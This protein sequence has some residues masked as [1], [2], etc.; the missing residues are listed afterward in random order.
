MHTFSPRAI[1]V[2]ALILALAP[3][4]FAAPAQRLVADAAPVRAAPLAAPDYVIGPDDVLTIVFWRDK[5]MSGDVVVR[6]D[7]RISLPLLNDIQAAGLTPEELRESLVAAAG[8]L[9]EEPSA[10]VVVKQI[11]SRR[12][13]I[14]GEVGKPGPYALTGPMTVVQLIALAGGLNEYADTEH[15][16]IMRVEIARTVA[17]RLNYRDLTKRKNLRQ[18]IALQPG[19]T[20]IVP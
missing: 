2:L 3:T 6:P 18:N 20:V 1:P 13:F 5:E 8:R 16:V 14:T 7:G 19:D 4:P 15:I 10:S 17:Y 11:N 12:V 9:L